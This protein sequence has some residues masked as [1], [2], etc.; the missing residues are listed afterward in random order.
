MNDLQTSD[1]LTGFDLARELGHPHQKFLVISGED[2]AR[3]F[4]GRIA[5][6]GLKLS[7]AAKVAGMSRQALDQRITSRFTVDRIYW[8]ACLCCAPAWTLVA[9][10]PTAIGSIPL[11]PPGWQAE[12]ARRIREGDHRIEN[13]DHFFHEL[14]AMATKGTP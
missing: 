5:F 8:L 6:L 11:P 14:A 3:N 10:S 13:F 4:R 2:I 7:D 9:D 1:D 12:V